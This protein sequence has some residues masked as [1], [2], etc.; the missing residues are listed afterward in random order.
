M[1]KTEIKKLS[2]MLKKY[3]QKEAVYSILESG[4]EPSVQDML[5]AGIADPRRVVNQLRTD[6][7]FSIYLNDRRD[8]RGN[9]TR[10][11]RLGSARRSA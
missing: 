7:G 5:T 1:N 10:R 3:T 11:Y 6:H 2:T 9:V 8:R 4:Y